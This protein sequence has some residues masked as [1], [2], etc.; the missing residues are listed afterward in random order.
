MEKAERERLKKLAEKA[1]DGSWRFESVEENEANMVA[2]LNVASPT[3]ILSLF[4]DYERLEKDLALAH[5]R[6]KGLETDVPYL[7]DWADIDIAASKAMLAFEEELAH[8]IG[9]DPDEPEKIRRA[10]ILAKV[11]TL[12]K[13]ANWLAKT[14]QERDESARLMGDCEIIYT[15]EEWRK[16][17]Q[18]ATKRPW[19]SSDAV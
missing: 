5:E 14:L 8:I 13:E 1:N 12:E 16:A 7:E 18:E 9:I 10:E 4:A 15:K 19:E 3:A 2:F 17:A 11:A 6:I